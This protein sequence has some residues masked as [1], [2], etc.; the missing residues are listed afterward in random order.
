[1]VLNAFFAWNMSAS[2]VNGRLEV[3]CHEFFAALSKE[4]LAYIDTHGNEVGIQVDLPHDEFNGHHSVAMKYQ[5][6]WSALS[7]NSKKVG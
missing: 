4:M 3:K 2:D 6:G 5:Q 1:M 7:V